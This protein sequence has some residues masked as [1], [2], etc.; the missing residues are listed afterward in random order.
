M[1]LILSS[2]VLEKDK[3][4][5]ALS[6]L[7]PLASRYQACIITTASVEYKEKNFHAQKLMDRLNL[8]DIDAKFIDIEFQASSELESCDIIIIN[9]GNPYHLLYHIK[10]SGTDVLLRRKANN[11]S[12]IYGISAGLLVLQSDIEIIDMISPEMNILG[13]KD[14]KAIGLINDIILPHYERFV[15]EGIIPV[16]TIEEYEKVSGKKVKTLED[17]EFIL[18]CDDA[19][20]RIN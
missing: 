15:N 4:R 7:L 16:G 20:E 18:Y 6:K 13:I 1:R 11:G 17:D 8:L 3:L 2:S 10:K 19:I 9:G 14:K 5:Y 12:V